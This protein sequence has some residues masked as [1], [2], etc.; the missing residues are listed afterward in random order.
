MKLAGIVAGVLC[1]GAGIW[2]LSQHSATDPTEGT[3]WF[4]ILAHGIG[5][6]FIGKGV[7]V[8]AVLWSRDENAKT[9]REQLAALQAIAQIE[10]ARGELSRKSGS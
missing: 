2:L 5:I 1:A 3:S 6:Y 4:E 10:A 7:F 8:A 9:Q